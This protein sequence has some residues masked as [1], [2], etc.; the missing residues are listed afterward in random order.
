MSL[1]PY[2]ERVALQAGLTLSCTLPCVVIAVWHSHTR[3]WGLL[4]F[5]ASLIV[6][7]AALVE[8]PRLGAF[9]YHHWSWQESCLSTAWPFLVVGLVPGISLAFIGVTSHMRSGWLKP[10]IIALL[11]A[12]AVPIVFFVLGIRRRLD[13]E[14]W[15]FLLTMP[16]L[17]EELVFRGVYQSLLNRV[18]GKPW[19]LANAEFGWGLIISAILFAGFNGLV[20]VDSQL[21]AR[22]VLASAI[23]PIMLSLVSGW[24]RERSDSVWP[25]V[26]GHNLSNIVI[27]VG[28][29]LV[30]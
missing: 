24:V 27:P 26:F 10:S 30:R 4:L 5:T 1:A 18:F 6:L 3:R 11:V 28:T 12:M 15:A 8:I 16:G 21:H 23:A 17:A 29:L 25:S 7:D 9:R 14:G 22:F 19:R 20:T 2:I 13:G